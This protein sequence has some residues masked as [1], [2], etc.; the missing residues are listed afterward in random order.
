KT[1][2]HLLTKAIKDFNDTYGLKL[3]KAD[4]TK[5]QDVLADPRQ[6]FN[7]ILTR[8]DAAGKIPSRL[9]GKLTQ[10]Y[11]D[12]RNLAD[13]RIKT[14]DK[15]K[16][17][18]QA[19]K[20]LQL[21]GHPKQLSVNDT[22]T[23]INSHNWV[24]DEAALAHTPLL[25]ELSRSIGL[26]NVVG[27][28][29][30]LD[31]SLKKASPYEAQVII[32]GQGL[33]LAGLISSPKLK[34][35][36][37]VVHDKKADIKLYHQGQQISSL[38]GKPLIT[39]RS[40]LLGQA[41]D[42]FNAQ[43][44]L[45][46]KKADLAK[47]QDVLADPRQTFNDILSRTDTSKTTPSRL[48]GKL[49]EIYGDIRNLAELQ[50]KHAPMEVKKVAGATP[51]VKTR[52]TDRRP[53]IEREIKTLASNYQS[54]PVQYRNTG[55]NPQLDA[56]NKKYGLNIT[57]RDLARGAQSAFNKALREGGFNPTL[58]I[59][60]YER[61]RR[62]DYITLSLDKKG[63][64]I[65]IGPQ[66]KQL[67]PP[68][69]LETIGIKQPELKTQ[70]NL[71]R[72]FQQASD[73]KTDSQKR[74]FDKKVGWFQERAKEG[75]SITPSIQLFNKPLQE[76]NSTFELWNKFGLFDLGLSFDS[77]NFSKLHT[78]KDIATY[79]VK[80]KLASSNA[81]TATY[82]SVIEPLV[83]DSSLKRQDE[84][85]TDFLA[86]V[87]YLDSLVQGGQLHKRAV[88]PVLRQ[89]GKHGLS[90]SDL[91]DQVDLLRSYDQKITA[92]NLAVPED[93]LMNRYLS[94]LSHDLRR[95]QKY[96]SRPKKEQKM[97]REQHLARYGKGLSDWQDDLIKIK[98]DKLSK[99]ID[100]LNPNNG[101][102]DTL[103]QCGIKSTQAML[104]EQGID[105]GLHDIAMPLIGK[106]LHDQ[107]NGGRTNGGITL[108]DITHVAKQKDIQLHTYKV[109]DDGDGQLSQLFSLSGPSLAVV[110]P[111]N[112]G[113]QPHFVPIVAVNNDKV[114]YVETTAQGKQLKTVPLAE[115]KDT[116]FDEKG[117]GFFATTQDLKHAGL[118]EV[119]S[120]KKLAGIY[121]LSTT[122]AP[123]EQAQALPQRANEITQFIRQFNLSD[124]QV[125]R[126]FP[127]LA[128]IGQRLTSY[129][130][131]RF[132]NRMKSLNLSKAAQNDLE[133][134]LGVSL[135]E[136]A[137]GLDS[138]QPGLNTHAWVSNV[139]GRH[140]VLRH[141][142]S[143][144][145]AQRQTAKQAYEALY[146][147]LH[148][149]G[150]TP[151]IF[152]G[153]ELVVSS[154]GKDFFLV[155]QDVRRLSD[156][157]SDTLRQGKTDRAGELITQAARLNNELNQIGVFFRNGQRRG[158]HSNI[159]DN[160][161]IVGDKLVVLDL[162]NLATSSM[163]GHTGL[164]RTHDDFVAQMG[165]DLQA[166]AS[167]RSLPQRSV[168]SALEPLQK[169][170]E[171][172]APA[173]K[174][175]QTATYKTKLKG[176]EPIEA[177]QGLVRMVSTASRLTGTDGMDASLVI[178]S[179]FR[180]NYLTQ[181]KRLLNLS[182]N[183]LITKIADHRDA[184]KRFDREIALLDKK[185]A[186]ASTRKERSE[187]KAQKNNLLA[188]HQ[189]QQRQD[190]L[191]FEWLSDF[192][193]GKVTTAAPAAFSS[194]GTRRLES[195]LDKQATQLSSQYRQALIE[196]ERLKHNS[197]LDTDAQKSARDTLAALSR[198][199]SQLQQQG[200]QIEKPTPMQIPEIAGMRAQQ[201]QSSKPQ[202][203][204]IAQTPFRAQAII[205]RFPEIDSRVKD[206]IRENSLEE[207]ALQNLIGVAE[208]A[209]EHNSRRRGW[210]Q[211]VPGRAVDLIVEFAHVPGM[212]DFL[213]GLDVRH[214]DK[215]RDA[216]R[217]LEVARHLQAQGYEV[218]ALN[219]RINGKEADLVI[220]KSGKLRRVEVQNGNDAE[221]IKGFVEEQIK[222]H[223]DA[224]YIT[225]QNGTLV[226]EQGKTQTVYH[227]FGEKVRLQLPII[228]AEN[229]KAQGRARILD[230]PMAG[231]EKDFAGIK[232]DSSL[233]RSV[234]SGLKQ[235]D[236]E[237][238]AQ[239]GQ[240]ARKHKAPAALVGELL[241]RADLGKVESVL[242]AMETTQIQD[243][244]NQLK[245]KKD[246]QLVAA[247]L[248]RD[249]IAKQKI[250][251]AVEPGI[252][253]IGTGWSNPVHNSKITEAL[254]QGR[255]ETIGETYDK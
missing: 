195:K 1:R 110:R 61:N 232:A 157:L 255:F 226:F 99:A 123:F 52:T 246:R 149:R 45:K 165:R 75:I 79:L 36:I 135:Q 248:A 34:D 216:I 134:A 30:S 77:A 244:R 5:P 119:S 83:T 109:K 9:H 236:Q 122:H 178:G 159:V 190:R 172:K 177:Q 65:E 124:Q 194:W 196:Y 156:E 199:I 89:V 133:T 184:A 103:R 205:E 71:Y 132:M 136:F 91:Q 106:I 202:S 125:Q 66:N 98:P 29:Y 128:P 48:R 43:Y 161:G 32:K 23:F 19:D 97:S 112:N 16:T 57:E 166:F 215:L 173:L 3:N 59:S 41:I 188:A 137:E 225:K 82:S 40:E 118:T 20:V 204:P 21:A 169:V 84:K 116:F 46:L 92:G 192:E 39:S 217:E 201:R 101:F 247:K 143:L 69:K 218:A 170:E 115:F 163:N 174:K 185:I 50:I 240:L 7:D 78:P 18:E 76:L 146:P 107:A 85:Q 167:S 4:L 150:L 212:N 127:Q 219:P 11:T 168:A 94:G 193:R 237:L 13:L 90:S 37:L 145:Q 251:P 67:T 22:L 214:P 208:L 96:I 114:L 95:Y 249:I 49:T 228:E 63:G 108:D 2:E 31:T 243:I 68:D 58:T 80:H 206:I 15:I 182:D 126:H 64:I 42:K 241:K 24:K 104:L 242:S 12:I 203:R 235:A 245:P 70:P 148:D 224:I 62:K 151:R 73:I 227:V 139:A 26:D 181:P 51:I 105:A 47:P 130:G 187:L 54:L 81:K 74:A 153:K 222:E 233:L 179:I 162:A 238:N 86:T 142:D 117:L 223:H 254:R 207:K 6:T 200:I 140:I 28:D 138:S 189:L 147:A 160:L 221:D 88:L 198:E 183:G 121:G 8:T 27:I 230:I 220:L 72:Q 252:S 154:R 210:Q 211:K 25:K 120:S 253:S 234:D 14:K 171:L 10:L 175:P 164:I 100:L 17:I 186:A 180:N 111:Q 38:R 131:A 239:M 250:E 60:A 158:A 35:S 33:A 113:G 191:A 93:E 102:S 129:R 144:S 55:T 155:Q 213:K 176:Q 56:F 197:P 152:G 209:L 44:G 229:I 231:F 53:A 87:N 141:F